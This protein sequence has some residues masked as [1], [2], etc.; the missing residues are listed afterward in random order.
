MRSLP[1]RTMVVSMYTILRHEHRFLGSGAMERM[2]TLS[3][4]AIELLLTLSI[5]DL[6]IPQSR[7]GIE[8]VWRTGGKWEFLSDIRK[9]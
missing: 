5:L 8:E 6:M 3:A 7:F 9:A 1:V 4:M 2:L